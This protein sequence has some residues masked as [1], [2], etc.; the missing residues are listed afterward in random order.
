MA[1]VDLPALL[2]L[3][4]V[5]GFASGIRLYAVVLIVGLVGWVDWVE[6]PAGLAVLAHPGV[7][8]A[9]GVMFG[10]EFVADK[11]P[12][13]DSLWDSLHTFIRIPAGAALAAGLLG[14]GTDSAAWGTIGALLGG[15]LAATS[16]FTKAGARAALN[17]SPEPVTNWA[18]SFSEDALV[19]GL[20]ALLFA[21]PW[22][23]FAVVLVL[24]VAA[25]W[26][27]WWLARVAR[28]VLRP[29]DR[30]TP[31]RSRA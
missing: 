18:A 28:R 3:A 4:A 22:A 9:A 31:L 14:V 2:A 20:L 8:I 23:A 21:W 25:V 10:V 11:I 13:V 29:D 24:V 5:L 15:S 19:A 7:L 27:L 17:T 16:H 1:A 6:L 12:V 30:A 26:L